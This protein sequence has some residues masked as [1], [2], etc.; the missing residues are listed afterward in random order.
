M[1][2]R[3]GWVRTPERRSRPFALLLKYPA[4]GSWRVACARCGGRSYLPPSVVLMERAQ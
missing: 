4:P 2:A 1:S 3:V